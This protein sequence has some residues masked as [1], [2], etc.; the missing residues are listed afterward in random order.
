MLLKAIDESGGEA[1]VKALVDAAGISEKTVR[2]D[3]ALL[4]RVGCG[5]NRRQDAMRF[6]RSSDRGHIE[7]PQAVP[8]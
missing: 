5:S 2:R 4:R 6:P 7:A 1:T 3:L 8:P